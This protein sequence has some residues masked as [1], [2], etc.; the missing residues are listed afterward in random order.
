MSMLLK[1]NF[2]CKR[3]Q[4]TSGLKSARWQP[5]WRRHCGSASLSGTG[6]GSAQ[7]ADGL[8]GS[9][10]L[11]AGSAARA[12][13]SADA[14]CLAVAKA[15]AMVRMLWASKELASRTAAEASKWNSA[16]ASQAA[17]A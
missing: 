9:G 2:T 6:D 13:N 3:E 11:A 14:G 17:L 1:Q 8:L 15:Q 12:S 4:A 5:T 16:G 10:S 7:P